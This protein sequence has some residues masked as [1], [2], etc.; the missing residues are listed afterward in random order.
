MS[1]LGR[2][3]IF[4]IQIEQMIRLLFLALL[5]QSFASLA[6]VSE[7][8]LKENYTIARYDIP[9]RDGIKL[10]TIVYSPKKD[11]NYPFLIN[12]TCY[13]ASKYDNYHVTVQPNPLLVEDLYILVYQD[14]RG[15]YLSEGEFDNMRPN[16]P[17]NRKKDIDESSDTYDTIDWLVKNIKNNN[18]KAGI[19]GISYPGFYSAASIPNAHPSLKAV[20]PQAPIS[21]FFFDDF[22]HH[23]AFLQSYTPAFPVFGYQKDTVT[24]ETW[25]TDK[26]MRMVSSDVN[27]AYS[28]YLNLG[29]LSNTTKYYHHD[30]FFWNQI[31]EHP[32]YD[33]FWQ[34]RNLLPHLTKAKPAVMVVGGWY[35]A[36]DLYGPLNIY[37]TI[38]KRDDQAYNTIVM[39]PW[40]HGGWARDQGKHTVN[41]VYYGDSISSQYQKEIEFQ[42]FSKFL[43]DKDV[44]LPEAH[45]YDT[46]TKKWMDFDE[47][48]S[49]KLSSHTLMFDGDILRVDSKVDESKEYS[50][51]SDPAHPVPHRS[52]IHTL[53]FT[54]RL[55][56]NDDQR[57]ASRRPDVLTFSTDELENDLIIGGEILADL[58][59][60]MTGSDADFIVKIID[61]YPMDHEEYDHNPSNVT[62]KGYQQLV[63]HEV[64]RGRYRNSYEHPE[65][66]QANTKT[67]VQFPLQDILH[68]FKKGHKLMVQ[69]QSTYF[70]YIDRNPQKY[71][72]NIYKAK[73]EDFIKSTITIHGSSKILINPKQNK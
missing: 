26:M 44:K 9:M 13:N 42:F 63:R 27:D 46:G 2:L 29:P 43:K 71:V 67:K 52:E 45:M 17:G 5:L 58:D 48:P 11:G 22:H 8:F 54:P 72:D 3:I 1:N 24:N 19:F 62:M 49:S 51:V 12:R 64:F 32:N 65:P 36:E 69:I 57:H 10:H 23:G 14:V 47:W 21:D 30:N 15:R 55:F 7:T 34:K 53:G 68:T 59:V 50:Y 31:I 18:K 70:P 35:D 16:I 20:S 38:E 41:H 66:F 56:I 73:E 37:K 33:E 28:F 25:F 39:G 60:S 61:V 6:Q 40:T 4:A